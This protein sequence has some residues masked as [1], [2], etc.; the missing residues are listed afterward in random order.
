MRIRADP[1]SGSQRRRAQH[2]PG[3]RF[4]EGFEKE[5]LRIPPIE[6]EIE[7][8]RLLGARTLALALNGKGMTPAALRKSG[9]ALEHSLGIPVA[10]PLE[11]GVASLVPVLEGFVAAERAA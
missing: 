4:F 9:A 8:I 10:L 7:L 6:E 11:E 2:A 5:G 3:R 1:R